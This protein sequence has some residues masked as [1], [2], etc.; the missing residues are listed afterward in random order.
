MENSI[1]QR[2][3]RKHILQKRRQGSD[4][5]NQHLANGNNDYKPP[6][7]VYIF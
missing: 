1:Q 3:N 6:I 2:K 4:T 5:P 7:D